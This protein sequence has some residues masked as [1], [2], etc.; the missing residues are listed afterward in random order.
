MGPSRLNVPWCALILL[1]RVAACQDELGGGLVFA[2]LLALGGEAPGGDRMAAAGGAPFAAA[3]RMVDRVHGDA[4]V[5]RTPPHPALAAGFADRDVH[6]VGVRHRPDR[7]HAAAVDEA[8]L[9]RVEPQDDVVAVTTDDL[10]IG[11]GR[12]RD[13]AALAEL[14]LDVVH[15]GAD[16]NVAER[17][18]IA[19]LHVD[20]LARHDRIAGGDPLRRQDIGE[21]AVLVLDE[22]NEGG[23]V[24]IVFEPLH[25]R[26]H[27]E[28]AA[29]EV[30]LAVR[31]LVA[32]AAEAHGDA[33][34]VVAAAGRA[35]ALGQR[36]DRVA[37]MQA[38]SV[39]DDQLALARRGGVVGFQCHRRYLTGPWS[40]QWCD[41]RRASRSHAWSATAARPSP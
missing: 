35:L 20:M 30:D 29:L 16:R 38:R 37:T 28:L 11:A 10:R 36:L 13:L 17:H 19:R 3:M 14:E 41:L 22:R 23:A 15:D 12:A 31:L 25:S 32:T 26:R 6:V 40:R 1:P 4:A 18:G 24:R 34:V 2:G 9:G 8:L 39:D 27:I 33:A 7:A 5:V 21:L